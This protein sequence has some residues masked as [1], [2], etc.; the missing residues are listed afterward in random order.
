MRLIS[1]THLRGSKH[2]YIYISTYVICVYIYICCRLKQLPRKIFPN[3]LTVCSS[4]KR[5]FVFCPFVD[6]VTN[7]NYPFAHGLNVLN[8]L[9]HLCR[10]PI[11]REE[12]SNRGQQNGQGLAAVKLSESFLLLNCW[13]ANIDLCL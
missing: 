13:L 3:P 8:E 1:W 11:K 7:A 2:I 6:E 12:Y 10:L 9:A 5:K 4:C